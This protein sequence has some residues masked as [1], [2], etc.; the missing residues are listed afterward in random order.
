MTDVRAGLVFLRRLAEVDA[1]RVAVVGHS[2]G[3]SLT[4]L[5]AE[6]EP[7]L[8]AGVIFSG[9]GYSW[10]RSSELRARLLEAVRHTAVPLFFIHA[11]NDYSTSSGKAL[12]AELERLGKPHRLKIYPPVGKTPDDG[13]D[14]P[15]NSI[16][17]WDPDVCAF[18]DRYMR[19]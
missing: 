11:A 4:V 1:E 3:G 6:R 18:L 8:R 5:L 19:K 16:G 14:F 2:F 17:T 10:D 12:D 9:A 15:N 7:S 13:H